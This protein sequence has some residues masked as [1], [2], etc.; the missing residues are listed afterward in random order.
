[1]FTHT[2]RAIALAAAIGCFAFGHGAAQ[3]QPSITAGPTV[4][5]QTPS[6]VSPGD[7]E[8]GDV[9]NLAI[10]IGGTDNTFRGPAATWLGMSLSLDLS[11]ALPGLQVVSYE[12]GGVR[13]QNIWHRWL[14]RLAE[15]RP[16][17]VG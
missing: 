2:F 3:A 8:A 6:P 10:T 5:D 13:R 16:R 12:G 1:M 15:H 4:T 11:A 9:V 14:R 7:L 17:L